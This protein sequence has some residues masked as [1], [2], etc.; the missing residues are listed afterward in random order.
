MRHVVLALA[1]TLKPVD[2]PALSAH[3]DVFRT[4]AVLAGAKRD[5]KVN[6]QVEGRSLVP[7][8]FNPKADWPDRYLVTHVGRWDKGDPPVKD[9]ECSIHNTRYSLVH[10]STL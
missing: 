10:A 6:A 9:G 3:I 2:V 8:L 7:L 4:L 5:D 1:G